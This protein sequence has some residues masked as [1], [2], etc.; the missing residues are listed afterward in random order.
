MAGGNESGFLLWNFSLLRKAPLTIVFS[1]TASFD[2]LPPSDSRF[3]VLCK[4][5]HNGRVVP[6]RMWRLCIW[7]G[8]RKREGRGVHRNWKCYSLCTGRDGRHVTIRWKKMIMIPIKT[9]FLKGTCSNFPSSLPPSSSFSLLFY[10][11]PNLIIF[12]GVEKRAD[13]AGGCSIFSCWLTQEN[14]TLKRIGK[15]TTEHKHWEFNG[16]KV[17]LIICSVEKPNK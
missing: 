13:T 9:N 16:C 8:L 17:A 10:G 15:V 3:L 4:E 1:H 12:S 11:F 7:N 2:F 6:K 5:M 14:I